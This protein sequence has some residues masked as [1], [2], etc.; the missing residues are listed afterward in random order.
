MQKY[1]LS[2]E[3]PKKQMNAHARPA[4]QGDANVEDYDVKQDRY[5]IYNIR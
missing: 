5:E 4:I 2:R 3:I 1:T